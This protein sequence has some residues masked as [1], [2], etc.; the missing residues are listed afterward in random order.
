MR[1]NNFP[2]VL[3][4]SLLNIALN[5]SSSLGCPGAWCGS[6]PS[7][8]HSIRPLDSVTFM[9]GFQTAHLRTRQPRIDRVYASHGRETEQVDAVGDVQVDGVN[10]DYCDDF[11]CTS[12][13]LVEQ[14]V[15]A[16]ARDLLR[17]RTWTSSLFSPS[18]E[19]KVCSHAI[20]L[21]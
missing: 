8:S 11:I 12:S 17:Q 9:S 16:L 14:T 2:A 6:I 13:P 7:N 15:K 5:M 10:R 20:I 3:K 1:S 18:V 21:L 4:L 19:Y